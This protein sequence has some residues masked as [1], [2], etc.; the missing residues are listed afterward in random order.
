MGWKA[1][2]S[3]GGGGNFEACPAGNHPAVCIAII[4]LGTQHE[5]Y[6]GAPKDSRKVF[7]CWEIP[8]EQ[9]SDGTNHIMG[10]EYT[11]S[12]NEKA[13]LRKLVEA[14]RNKK[15]G[16]GEEFDLSKLLGAAC[17]LNVM[18]DEKGD[19]VYARIDGASALPKGMSKPVAT[20]KPISFNLDD[21]D[22]SDFPDDA[23]LPWSYGRK[24]STIVQL[25]PEWQ[26]KAKGGKPAAK[27]EPV[28][29]GVGA[30]NPDADDD[31]TF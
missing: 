13:G 31:V 26:A 2:A 6:Q 14:W 29:A 30:G 3:S 28:G 7:L 9:K 22:L 24:L 17:M 8:T 1:T 27:Q 23:W 25:S 10:R 19:K 18:N 15:F 5:N 4:D 20:I 11:Y 16:E 21:D 12:F